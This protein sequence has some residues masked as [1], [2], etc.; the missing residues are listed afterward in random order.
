MG[1]RGGISDSQLQVIIG[2]GK[3][4]NAFKVTSNI[5]GED[6]IMDSTPLN[7]MT[8]ESFKIF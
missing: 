8:P 7:D 5:Y 3:I 2:F 6:V 1:G 4:K